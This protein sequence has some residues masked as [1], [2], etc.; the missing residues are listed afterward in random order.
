MRADIPLFSY[1][2]LQK[3]EVQLGSYGRLL[4]G[5]ADTLHGFRL[6]P[7][8][9]RNADVVGLSGLEVHSIAVAT[10]D[11]DDV[12]PGV[13]F[14]LSADE[15]AATDTYEGDNYQRIEVVLASGRRAFAYVAPV[16]AAGA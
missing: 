2:T 15:L 3:A 8:T 6:E 13:V 11:A 10:G 4:D 9:I 7:I 14:L 5:V 12:V 16:P 1:G